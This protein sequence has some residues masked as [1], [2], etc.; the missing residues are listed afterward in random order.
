MDIRSVSDIKY[1]LR[2]GLKTKLIEAFGSELVA[3]LSFDDLEFTEKL[4]KVLDWLIGES[5]T[6]VGDWI[7]SSLVTIDTIEEETVNLRDT[8][9]EARQIIE[10]NEGLKGEE[11]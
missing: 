7:V 4:D 5:I 1:N 9:E 8:L 3:T 10:S 2:E 11:R 6:G